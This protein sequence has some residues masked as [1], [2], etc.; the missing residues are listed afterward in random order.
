MKFNTVLGRSDSSSLLSE[1]VALRTQATVRTKSVS[2]SGASHFQ[3]V[4]ELD[5]EAEEWHMI[6]DQGL[7]WSAVDGMLSLEPDPP[8]AVAFPRGMPTEVQMLHPEALL[9]WGRRGES[10]YPML[11]Q[12]IGRR[13][14][15]I[16]FE[17]VED[18]FRATAVINRTTGIIEKMAALGDLT[19]LTEVELSAA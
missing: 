18:P 15:L 11:I 12:E 4:A 5:A 2:Q 17:H 3:F 10:F 8:H 1:I 7:R 9:M 6:T 14:L 19:I 16:T 13:S